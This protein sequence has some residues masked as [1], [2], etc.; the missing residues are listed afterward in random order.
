[1]RVP[2]TL[3]AGLVIALAVTGCDYIVPPIDFSTPTPALSGQ[4]WGAI[5]TGVSEANGA[6]HVDLS[7]RND[8]GD[9]SAMNVAASTAEVIDGSGKTSSCS[10]AFVGTSVFVN[11]GGWFLPPGFVMKG[12]TGGSLAA[13][14]TQL[15]YVECAGVAKAAGQ[16][17]AIKYTY[18]TGPFNYYI[19]SQ[20][21][22]GT[23]NLE[24]D[25]VVPDTKY[26]VAQK[27][28]GN[29]PVKLGAEIGAI[30]KCT[31]QLTDAKR[32]DTGFEF[33]WKSTN[34]GTDQAYIHIGIPP[35]IGAD[36]ILYGFYRSPHLTNDLITPA[37]GGTATWTT[38]V[39]V[40]KDGTGFYILV[41]VETKQQKYFVDHVI[42]ITDK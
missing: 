3:A 36:G 21:T 11:D 2:R 16:K 14:V 12:Y 40:P 38:A 4:G 25:K 39:V 31:V 29:E 41:P 22:S 6:L 10:T 30:N 1:M 28:S 33:S 26:P 18:I 24:L 17:L 27:V 7:L 23:L 42:D 32:T 5:V 8:T 9:W 35:V 13:P 19:A 37:G 20:K 34:P 15:N